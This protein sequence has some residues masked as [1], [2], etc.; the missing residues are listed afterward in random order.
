MTSHNILEIGKYLSVSLLFILFFPVNEVMAT[1]IVGGELSYRCLGNDRYEVKLKVRRD[2]ANANEEAVFDDPAALWVYDGDFGQLPNF[3]NKGR[4]LLYLNESD[5]IEETVSDP[6]LNFTGGLCVQTAL[7]VDTITLPRRPGGYHLMYQRCCRNNII[8]NITNPLETGAS[9]ILR[10]SEAALETCSSSPV[11]TD[12][13]PVSTCLNENIQFDQS[14][15]SDPGDSLVY[16]LF[17]PYEGATI[18]NPNPDVTGTI[19]S[20][21]DRVQWVSPTYDESYMLGNQANPLTID[22]QTGLLTG[23]PEIAGTFL[24]GIRVEQYRSGVLLSSV[25]RDF[26]ITVGDCGGL[27]QADFEPSGVYCEGLDVTFENLSQNANSYQWFFDLSDTSKSSTEFEPTY[28]FADTGTY[29]VMLVVTNDSIC[30]DTIQKEII[31]RESD[32]N[33]DFSIESPE[34]LDSFFVQL[35]DL[36]TDST[37]GIGTRNWRVVTDDS[38]YNFIGPNPMF[39]L[40]E[41]TNL[42]VTLTIEPT[43]GCPPDSLTREVELKFIN[44]DLIGDSLSICAGES[45]NLL[46]SFDPDLDYLWTPDLF[47]S[48]NNTAPNP[49]ATPDSSITY[50]VSATD[51]LCEVTDSV[52]VEVR[53]GDIDIVLLEGDSCTNE[54]VLTVVGIEI[55]SIRWS[56][57][58]GFN[59]IISREDTLSITI[60]GETT[61]YVDVVNT[62]LNCPLTDSITLNN[63]AIDVTYPDTLELCIGDTVSFTLRN[64][65]PGDT[66][67]V[68][69]EDNPI[70]IGGQDSST[71]I[72]FKEM[73]E[74]DELIFTIRNQFGCELMDTLYVKAIEGKDA[75]FTYERT[76]GDLTVN[77]INSQTGD[78]WE[79]D[80]GDGNTSF[81]NSPTHTYDEPGEYTVTLTFTGACS[82]SSTQTINVNLI[83]T[84]FPTDLEVCPG[85]S[86]F[87]NPNG[88]P[89]YTYMW[90]PEGP[91]DDPNAVN[92]EATVNETT[93]FTVIISEASDTCTIERT[94]TVSVIDPF[95]V[96]VSDPLIC[97]GDTVRLTATPLDPD[98][99][100]TYSWE[101]V[102]FILTDPTDSSVLVSVNGTTTF[103]VTGRD[104]LGCE[105]TKTITV[106]VEELDP[107]VIATATP[108]TID[109]G[110]DSQ[111]DV[112]NGSGNWTYEWVPED[113]LDNPDIRNP[114]ATPRDTTV[115]TVTITTENG[116]KFDRT[117][118]VNVDRPQCEPPF[119]FLPNAFSPNGDGENDV[120][121]VRGEFVETVEL[122]IY[123]R[124]G[125]KVFETRDQAMG[126]DGTH[127]GKEN[128]PG[129]FAYYLMVTCEGGGEHQEQ[130]SINLLR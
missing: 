79:W 14:A 45:T 90:S 33:V 125:E 83:E 44:L 68:M 80:F 25:I 20:R 84:D 72:L 75:D 81:E 98:L 56:E 34:C 11:I 53:E 129:V 123:N 17:T 126:W 117:V 113:F 88:N 96:E 49:E 16:S 29:D 50:Y 8:D 77:F 104:S 130:G 15:D 76:C 70:I 73:L 109:F 107:D 2:C 7:Y 95:E 35:T 24:I 127:N 111:L 103:S 93:T 87:L 32:L 89:D 100:L 19:P 64:N 30:Y 85:Q 42:R 5:T 27:P 102:E 99:D 106:N 39:T 4:F 40:I 74:D 9:Y 23:L 82:S 41:E 1:H 52:F 105:V 101:P 116:C 78:M 37:G 69:W 118:T 22:P 71:V 55:D 65:I 43:N 48:P 18:D 36:S 3:A 122:I 110:D 108:P 114:L 61:I 97:A 67:S 58:P 60:D 86:V 13:P 38:V 62:E 121:F 46:N 59:N 54:R 63:F 92:P 91:L 66:L 128:E 6:C 12:F 28:E 94:V 57:D 120:L 124:W 26:Q 119:V 115:F 112:E 10:I 21:P 31:I 51:G 47:L